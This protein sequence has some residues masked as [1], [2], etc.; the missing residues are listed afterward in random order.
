MSNIIYLLLPSIYY[1]ARYE[2]DLKLAGI[3]YIHRISD[4]RFTG[5]SRRNFQMFREL[6][7]DT[8]LKNVVL[9]TNMWGEVS[10]DVG[11]AREL[12]LITDFFKTVLDKGAQL[13]RHHNT[14]K[15]A[16]DIIRSI[17]KNRPMALQIQR[18]L[19]DEKKDIIDTAAGEA[20]NKELNEHIRRHQ[21]DLKEVRNEMQ[22]LK[23]KDGEAMKELEEE[24]RK[25]KA[26]MDKMSSDSAGMTSS[27]L[28][29]K[30]RMGEAMRQMQEQFRQEG[31]MA[32][33]AYKQQM[34]DFNKRLQERADAEREMIQDLNRRLQ[35][36]ID[37]SAAEREAMQNQIKHL[38]HQWDTRP[39]EGGGCLIM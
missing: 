2:A 30:K 24:T 10:Q 9:V 34:E 8:S 31:E 18:E 37:V 21:A 14:V 12:E 13:A 11:E 4:K 16:H 22:A 33:L 38:Q 20:V 32:L 26:Q 35:E 7:G 25:L 29:E 1:S 3:V 28:D 17:M 39:H 15:S 6:C 19:I 36:R 27:Y 23:D 5:N